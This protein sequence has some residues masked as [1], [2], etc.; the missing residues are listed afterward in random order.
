[1]L[2]VAAIGEDPHKSGSAGPEPAGTARQDVSSAMPRLSRRALLAH[3]AAAAFGASV[4]RATAGVLSAQ[5]ASRRD[6]PWLRDV[7]GPPPATTPP[8]RPLSPLL[9]DS[10]GRAITT[11]DGWRRRRTALERAWLDELGSLDLERGRPPRVEILEQDRV[12]DVIRQRVRYLIEPDIST[13]AYVLAPH[14]AGDRRPGAVVFHSTTPESI[15]QPAGLADMREK[16]L[17]LSLARRGFVAIC[18]RNFLWPETARMAAEDQTRRFRARHPR[19]M[20]MA[21]MLFDGQVALDLLSA[22]PDVDRDRIGC[23]GHSL[24]AKEALYLAAFD[25]RVKAVV[26]SEGGVGTTMSNW[27]AEWYLGARARQPGFAREHHELLALIAP[28]PFL[29]V[30]GD[31]ADGAASWP[32]VAA[33]QRVYRL[34]GEPSRLGLLNHGRGHAVPP[35][36]EPRLLEWLETYV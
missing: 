2:G 25:P 36:V 24:G 4:G 19:A 6:V 32:Y 13:E 1:V 12:G 28:R 17:G 30:G 9:V 5:V 8:S 22:R 20:G 26:S 18:P 33:A 11:L 31:S 10:A 3:G 21:K 29:L 23:I 34:Y 14:G 7:L 16:H 27:D 35:E 15:R